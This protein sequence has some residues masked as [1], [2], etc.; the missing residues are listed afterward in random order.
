MKK[1]F[2]RKNGIKSAYAALVV[3]SLAIVVVL[4]IV[5][6]ALADRYPM[7]IDLTPQKVFALSEETK[8]FIASLDTQV[9]IRVL[10]T[11]ERFQD[12]SIY[13]AQANEIMSLFAK[14]SGAIEIE[15]IDYVSNPGF[16]AAYP[17]LSMKHGDVLVSGAGRD[18]L[19]KTEELFHYTYGRDGSIAI[20][21]SRAEEAILSAVLYVT[22]SELP[23]AA[24]IS[25][26]GE[27]ETSAFEALLRSNNY[28]TETVNLLTGNL[29]ADTQ[30]ALLIAPTKDLSPEEITLLD[31]FLT[32]NGEYGKS[33]FY[34]AS[35]VQPA[36]PNLEA[37]LAEW[38][39]RAGDGMVFETDEQRVYSTQPFYA[40][41]DYAEE[42]YAA[43]VSRADAPMLV[44]VSRP[45]EVLFS[46]QERYV[47][48]TLLEFGASAGVRPSEAGDDFTADMA[49]VRGPIPALVLCSYKVTD[50]SNAS[51][52]KASSHILACGSAEVAGDFVIGSPSFAN[53]EYLI[54]VLND[55][56]EKDDNIAVTP[57]TIVGHALNLSQSQADRFGNLFVFVIPAAVLVLGIGIWLYRRHK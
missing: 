27:T 48:E 11:E 26:H 3:V 10:A 6:G 4:N 20:A 43:Q 45:L 15:Y 1:L 18:K 56:C 54:H 23:R 36:L 2:N 35:P 24:V 47:T 37:F 13:N 7:S 25:G 14:Q 46:Q 8:S 38:G 5:M 51:L 34:C 42:T 31:D 52:V 17:D 32:N 19:V 12:T 29:S 55:L 49:V 21:S 57:K 33:L 9:T 40:V 16:A 30:L 28:E 39:V 22:S 53:A 44:A 50:P 41:A